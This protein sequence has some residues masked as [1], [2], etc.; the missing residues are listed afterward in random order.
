MKTTN[1]QIQNSHQTSRTNTCTKKTHTKAC[2]NHTAENQW[3]KENLKSSKKKKD[4]TYRGSK[5][6]MN[7][8]FS[9]EIIQGRS[10]NDITEKHKTGDL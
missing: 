3:G 4:I 7:T 9:S 2:H 6:K 1:P 8:N 10:W 5:I